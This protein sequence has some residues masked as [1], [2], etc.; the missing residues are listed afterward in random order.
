VRRPRD[1]FA[2]AIG[3]VLVL[4]AL[5]TINKAPSGWEV[6]FTELVESGPRWFETMLG[7]G[8]SLSLVYAVV[9]VIGLVRGGRER[10]SALWDLVIVS[11]AA[12]GIVVLLSFLVNHAWPYVFPEIDLQNPAP[13][14]PV[15]R[16][17]IVTAMLLV[18][19]PHV[20]RPVR[21]FGWIAI[22]STAVASVGLSYGTP[23]HTIG[24]IGLGV[25]CAG[26]L[27]VIEGSP[28]GYPDP[29]TVAAALASLGLSVRRL[30]VAPVQ[31]W[32]VIRFLGWADDGTQIEVKA[33]G[34]DAFDSQLA[35]KIWHTLWYR[36]TSRAV[37]YSRLQAVEH[38]ALVTLIAGRFGVGVPVLAA[39]G[40][41]TAEVSLIAFRDPG[42]S[43]SSQSSGDLTDEI[44]VAI[45]G[46]V[47]LMHEMS[48][49]HGSMSASSVRIGVEGPIITEF[50]LGSLSAEP[51]DVGADVVELLFS[52]AVLVGEE[53]AAR[54]ALEG[55]GR[56][57]LVEA[58][59]Y[60]QLPAVSP[61]TRRLAPEPKT[62]VSNLRSEIG[63]LTEETMPDPV[64]LRRVTAR[65]LIMSALLL[66]V[67]FAIIPLF[68]S[69]DYSEIW[70]VLQGAD[71]S[72]M[73]AALLVGH[74]QFPPQAT[75]TM[76]AVP[77]KLPFWPLLTLQTASQFVSLAIPSAAGRV[78][79]NAAFL[80]KFGVP[81]AVA[82][83][84]G[85]IDGFSGFLVQ[86]GLMITILVFGDVD[87]DLID[88]SDIR[89]ALVLGVIVLIALGVILALARIRFLRER[90]GP[91]LSQA[92]EALAVVLRQPS[93]AI[94]LL[95]SNFVYWNVLG[96]TLWLTLQAVGASLGYGSALFIAAGT[97][98]FAGFMPVPGG[99]GVAEATMGALLIAF[100]ID[101][102]VALA[103]TAS[104]RV[105]TFYLPALEGFF[106][107]RWLERNQYI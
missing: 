56:E 61:A 11:A 30:E 25:F 12:A 102:S 32:G 36:E 1:F 15:M 29:D 49:S 41:A 95:A 52:L 84:Q 91:I 106:G 80:H 2:I 17:A 94:G 78:A 38:E 66:L 59:P 10:R 4:W 19:D 47:R 35:A 104:Y 57:R 45:W 54:T 13:Q 42:F 8:Y 14:F 105:I 92:R 62:I 72:L 70:D 20:A 107:T 64:K 28:A 5:L 23:S 34:R 100:G 50:A 83:A 40:S 21:R 99:I 93:R 63:N 89:W 69:V 3:L 26:L 55:L 48:I 88:T 16:M 60:L 43:L 33:L 22:L 96:I 31:T 90:I 51:A 77:S 82:V 7:L 67:A 101:D 103:V 87:L 18:V 58:L 85:A 65:S 37:S 79:M 46:Q 75:A 6:A 53:R 68:V 27:L 24:S 86:A 44:L 74:L 71:W 73:I 97:S 39:V 81:V 9:V 76:F 98:L